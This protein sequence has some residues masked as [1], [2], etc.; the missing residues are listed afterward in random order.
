MHVPDEVDQV[1]HGLG[2]L[3][4]VGRLVLQDGALLLDGAR[5][6]AFRAAVF[7]QRA[8]CF[9]SGISM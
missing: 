2:A 1:P 6:A 5:H 8:G 9:P 3:Q 4:R 7:I